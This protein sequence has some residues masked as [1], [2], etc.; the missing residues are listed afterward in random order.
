MVY[1]P[2]VDEDSCT[3]CKA[4][5]IHHTQDGTPGRTAASQRC[6]MG[7]FVIPGGLRY[8]HIYWLLPD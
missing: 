3:V 5:Y 2:K 6:I 8:G 4:V 1:N 7:S